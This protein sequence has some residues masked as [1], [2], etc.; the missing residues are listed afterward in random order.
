MAKLYK[1]EKA[2]RKALKAEIVKANGFVARYVGVTVAVIP[3]C[4]GHAKFAVALCGSHD[5][6]NRKR[7]EL[8]AM[9]RVSDMEWGQGNPCVMPQNFIEAEAFILSLC[10]AVA[11]DV[12][13]NYADPVF[14]IGKFSE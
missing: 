3:T 8:V 1:D 4:K 7:G 6:F 12:S 2:T 5:K 11:N 9:Q 10:A 14:T 13:C